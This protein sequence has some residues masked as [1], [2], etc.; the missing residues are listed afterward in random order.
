MKSEAAPT[1]LFV[2]PVSADTRKNIGAVAITDQDVDM[3][4]PGEF[5]NDTV[6]E[7]YL[8]YVIFTN[9]LMLQMDL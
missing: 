2:Y 8:K 5:L 1:R 9:W 4:K 7:F 3:L 6:I